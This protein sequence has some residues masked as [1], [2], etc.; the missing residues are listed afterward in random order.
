MT[1][2]EFNENNIVAYLHCGKCLEEYE[3][4]KKINKVMS[5]KDYARTQT[6]WTKQG[7]QVW[8]NRHECNVIHIDF[9]GAKHT[10]DTTARLKEKKN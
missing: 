4:D 1:A 10:A 8:C 5:P 7:I 2:V 6:G 3:Q 9:D